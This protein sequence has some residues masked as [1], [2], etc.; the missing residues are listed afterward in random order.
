M[1][2]RESYWKDKFFTQCLEMDK[3][4]HEDLSKMFLNAHNVPEEM[5]HSWEQY[6]KLLQTIAK[7]VMDGTQSKYTVSIL[8]ISKCNNT[9]Y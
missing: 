7:T 8:T 6:K 3:D 1:E 9:L 5:A 4:D 2:K